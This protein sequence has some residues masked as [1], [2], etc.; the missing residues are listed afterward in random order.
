MTGVYRVQL[1]YPRAEAVRE[2]SPAP[3]CIAC[4][5]GHHE[6]PMLAHECC[7][8]PCHGTPLECADYKV[9]A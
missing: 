6:Q 3:I 8:C 4:A 7:D 9:A 5:A 1:A 2:Q